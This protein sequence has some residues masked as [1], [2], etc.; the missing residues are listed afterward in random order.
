MAKFGRRL[1]QCI[2][3]RNTNQEA[4][5]QE[6]RPFER[7]L[8]IPPEFAHIALPPASLIE[9]A[10]NTIITGKPVD[11]GAVLAIP[12]GLAPGKFALTDIE[13]QM[14]GRGTSPARAPNFLTG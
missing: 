2:P 14:S 13:I 11:F 6:P 10:L 5:N 9:F 7:L 3:Q 8:A 4:A 12:R 1:H